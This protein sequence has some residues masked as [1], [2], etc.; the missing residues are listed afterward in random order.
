MPGTSAR[1]KASSPRPAMTE[2]ERATTYNGVI[3]GLVPVIHVLTLSP[4]GRGWPGHR[5]EATLRRLPA[6]TENAWDIGAKQSFV[7][8][9]GHD[10]ERTGHYLQR[11]HH[12]ACPGDPR[13]DFVAARTWMAGTRPA[14]TER[15]AFCASPGHD[16]ERTGH[17]LQR[18][19]HRACPGDP[20][21]DFGTARKAWM[22]GTS[23]GMT[24]RTPFCASPGHDGERTGH[25]LQR[26]HHRACPGDPRP[27]F[28][29]ARTWMAGTSARSN[30]SSPRGHDG[31]CLGHRRE[32]KLRRLARP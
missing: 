28:V 2:R 7:A 10:G 13:P 31:E 1:S 14:M 12:R 32:A 25:Y 20:R 23:P 27:D 21:P 24:E 9:P 17:Y 5:R 4:Q 22:A 29:A 15:P 19:H 16:G 3:T 18:R 26:R 11:R 30:A 6:M 8:S